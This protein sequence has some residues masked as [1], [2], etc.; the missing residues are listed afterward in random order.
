MALAAGE[1]LP[2][3][4]LAFSEAATNVPVLSFHIDRYMRFMLSLRE[5][6]RHVSLIANLYPKG[7]QP[8]AC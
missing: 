2:P 5:P 6:L 4:L 7:G 8:S 3:P 1:A